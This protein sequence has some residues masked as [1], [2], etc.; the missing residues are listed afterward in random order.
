[1]RKADRL[2]KAAIYARFAAERVNTGETAEQYNKCIKHI[3]A[4][5]Y[6][7]SGVYTDE[8]A[9]GMHTDHPAMTDLK[10]DAAAGAFDVVVVFDFSR[11]A[12][13][14]AAV[15]AFLDDMQRCGVAVESV[16]G[17]ERGSALCQLKR[18]K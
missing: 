2:K 11:I 1:M 7:L 3:E 13:N 15:R 18:I 5:G 6:E 17:I 10:A 4:R 8:R 12:R 16:K 14:A 9:T